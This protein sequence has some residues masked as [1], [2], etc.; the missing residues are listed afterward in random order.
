MKSACRN[1]LTWKRLAQAGA[2]L[3]AATLL[4]GYVYLTQRAKMPHLVHSGPEERTV[5]PSSKLAILVRAM[6]TLDSGGNFAEEDWPPVDDKD[7][8]IP[9]PVRTVNV[10][11]EPTPTPKPRTFMPGS[12]YDDV[13]PLQILGVL[14]APG[15]ES[16]E[17]VRELFLHPRPPERIVMPG[18]KSFGMPGEWMVAELMRKMLGVRPEP[19][20]EKQKGAKP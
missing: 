1:I 12:K 4:G 16:V 15:D 13:N 5:A 7:P 9:A 19:S 18:S 2:I 8:R 3:S 11:P 6:P 17:R 10:L 20:P 14:K